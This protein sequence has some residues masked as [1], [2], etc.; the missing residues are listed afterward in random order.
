[1][2]A[3]FGRRPVTGGLLVASA[4]L[5]VLGYVV[6]GTQFDWPGVLDEPGTTALDKY[7][8]AEQAI[9]AGF[10]VMTL[11]SL[12]L[13]PAAFGLQA[14]TA[15]DQTAARVITAFGVLGAFAQML[16]WLRWPITV[17]SVADA[18][19]AAQGDPTA[20]IAVATSYDVLNTYAGGALGEHLGW[21]LQGVWAVGVFAIAWRAAGVPR[22]VAGVGLALSAV[23]GVSVPVATA[24]GADVLE[25]WALNAYTAWYVWLLVF[26]VVLAVR[27]V[28]PPEPA[29]VRS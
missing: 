19:I 21:L 24:L 28:G 2:S 27:P 1:M 6:L 8:A 13:I 16:G 9:R 7:V 22:W 12:V 23:W 18:W 20:E 17:P 3:G 4:L 11:A 15:R 5:S 14:A 10:Y 25:F 29:E 26:G